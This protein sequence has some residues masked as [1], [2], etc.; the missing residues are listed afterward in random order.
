MVGWARAME[1]PRG[2]GLAEA[3]RQRQRGR[4]KTALGKRSPDIP[5]RTT[6]A[7]AMVDLILA[8][9]RMIS[10]LGGIEL[11]AKRQHSHSPFNG[12]NER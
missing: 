11:V 7:R 4:A 1:Y 9:D 2:G 10:A 5:V 12:S 6:A 3:F 8:I